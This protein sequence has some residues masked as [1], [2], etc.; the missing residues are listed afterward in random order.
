MAKGLGADVATVRF[1]CTEIERDNATLSRLRRNRVQQDRCTYIS[2]DMQDLLAIPASFVQAPDRNQIVDMLLN[3]SDH[4]CSNF[5]VRAFAKKTNLD[6][7]R[8]TLK[9][10]GVGIA[11]VIA[12]PAPAVSAGIGL[13]NLVTGSAVDNYN[14]SFYLEKTF[15]VMESA[16]G[17]ERATVR[18]RIVANSKKSPADY[19]LYAAL[20]DIRSYDDACSIERG[21]SVLSE[22]TA[23]QRD[24]AEKRLNGAASP[25]A[26][27]SRQLEALVKQLNETI[28][29]SAKD[30]ALV[31]ALENQRKAVEEALR[32]LNTEAAA[33]QPQP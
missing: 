15:Q 13:T 7:R 2:A 20:N 26:E 10:I 9:D 33:P 27:Q 28:Q 14:A 3:V 21:L 23:V 16:I 6:S 30:N 31:S 8:N 11:T 5:L 29:K 25:A 18:A 32:R 4:N 22:M 17:K 1:H 19:G 24:D 12:S